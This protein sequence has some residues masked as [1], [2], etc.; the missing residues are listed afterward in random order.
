[1]SIRVLHVITTLG[2][3]GAERQLVQLVSNTA[4]GE[5][6]HTV[7]HLRSPA[8]FAPE[9]ERAGNRV[10]N[11]NLSGKHPWLAGARRL[12]AAMRAERPDIVQTWLY[13]AAIVARLAQLAVPRAPLLNTLHSTDYDPETIRAYNL[14]PHRIN[15]LRLVDKW[16]ARLQTHALYLPVSQTVADSN[17]KHLGLTPARVRVMYNS[18]DPRSLDCDADAPRRLR[19]ELDIPAEAI[20]FLN[21]GRMDLSKGQTHLL[22]AFAQVAAAEAHAYL[23]IVGE[24]F[25]MS[26]LRRL[27]DELGLA[28][29]VRLTGRRG[30]VG[31]FLQMADIFVF[32]SLVEGLPL[33]PVEA[34]IKGLPCIAARIKPLLEM[35]TDSETGVLVAPGAADELATAM[36]ALARDPARRKVLGAQA[37]SEAMRRFHTRA[38]IPQWEALYRQV[39]ADG[40]AA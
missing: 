4:R 9:I 11:F 24:G 28:A 39:V 27:V 6:A 1:M 33:A 3:G 20:V 16:T 30:D 12:A 10:I 37:Q 18:I 7:C 38:A 13:D 2:R 36:L 8:E 23:V 5:F 14:S 32:P 34:M 35:I 40:R 21:V 25:L 15:L 29:R 22:R 31:A 17:T 26:E 19:Q